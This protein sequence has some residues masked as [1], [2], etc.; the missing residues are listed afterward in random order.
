MCCL[1]YALLFNFAY[2]KVYYPE[3]LIKKKK[4]PVF[5]MQRGR[6]YVPPTR[7][8]LRTHAGA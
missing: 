3:Q 2:Y 6:I 8:Q 1:A 4:T 5:A 7:H